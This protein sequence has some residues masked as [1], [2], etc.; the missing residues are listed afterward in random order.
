MGGGIDQTDQNCEMV[1]HDILDAARS[2]V[3]SGH[4][5]TLSKFLQ[6]CGSNFSVDITSV[7]GKVRIEFSKMRRCFT[8]LSIFEKNQNCEQVHHDSQDINYSD[9]TIMNDSL[10]FFTHE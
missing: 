3:E 7:F 4:V 6:R 9:A 2:R 5:C 10:N 8:D 1:Y